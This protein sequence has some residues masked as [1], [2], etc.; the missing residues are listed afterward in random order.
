M[1]ARSYACGRR[2]LLPDRSLPRVRGG[3]SSG[4]RRGQPTRCKAAGIARPPLQPVRRGGSRSRGPCGKHS[5]RDSHLNPCGET[6]RLRRSTPARGRGTNWFVRNSALRQR[7]SLRIRLDREMT[8]HEPLQGRPGRP[9]VFSNGAIRFRLSI[10]ARFR[11]AL[12]RASGTVPRLPRPAGLA[13]SG[14]LD[15]V[16]PTDVRAGSARRAGCHAIR[17][18]RGQMRCLTSFGERIAT[19]TPDRQTAEI[20]IRVALK[21][22]HALGIAEV[23]RVACSRRGKGAVTSQGAVRINA[24]PGARAPLRRVASRRRPAPG[25]EPL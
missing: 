12:R 17:G 3:G 25:G 4:G 5:L 23:F 20:V 24:A 18:G 2:R 14:L 21:R 6:E 22:F 9:P 10:D 15:P 8:C 7:T 16:P 1:R 11:L 13:R 19:R